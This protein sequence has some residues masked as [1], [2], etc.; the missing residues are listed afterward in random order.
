M[1]VN[2]G[3]TSQE[4]CWEVMQPQVDQVHSRLQIPV[5]EIDDSKTVNHT[6][7]CKVHM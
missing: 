5:K 7:I 3:V 6:V 4:S 2:Q 1:A